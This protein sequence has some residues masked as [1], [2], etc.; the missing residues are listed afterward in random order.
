MR[1][2]AAGLS[3]Y[4]QIRLNKYSAFIPLFEWSSLTAILTCTNRFGV[5]RN[6]KICGRSL[7]HFIK[8]VKDQHKL[9]DKWERNRGRRV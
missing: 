6:P 8:N 4:P 5:R 3:K 7:P 9:E 1:G 2:S